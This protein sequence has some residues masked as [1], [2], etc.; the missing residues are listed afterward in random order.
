[1][2]Y[3]ISFQLNQLPNQ[4]K[5]CIAGFQQKCINPVK[6]SDLLCEYRKNNT[7]KK[8]FDINKNVRR[9]VSYIFIYK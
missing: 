6:A 7:R 5:K 1:M 9:F 3:Y 4:V 8:N 2:S